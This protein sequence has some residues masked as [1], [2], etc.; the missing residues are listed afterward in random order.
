MGHSIEIQ[1]RHTLMARFLVCTIPVIGHVTPAI[2]IAQKLVQNGHEVW[3]YTGIQF[4]AKVEATGAHFVRMQQATDYSDPAQISEEGAAIRRQLTGIKQLQFDLKYVFIDSAVGQLADLTA[5]LTQFPADVVLADSFFVGASWLHEKGGPVWA[6]LGVSILFAQSGDVPPV[7]FGWQPS[8]SQMGKWRDRLL[9]RM[10]RSLV[11]GEVTAYATAARAK[12]GLD[13]PMPLVFDLVSPYLYLASTVPSFEYPRRDLPPQVHFVG[14]AV[15]VRSGVIEPLE[16]LQNLPDRPIVHVTQ[17]T[18]SNDPHQ[19]LIPTFQALADENVSVIATTGNRSLADIDLSTLPDNARIERYIPYPQLLP[20]VDL[21]ITN[22]G[23][24]GVQAALA[25]G[26]P[27][28]TAGKT[29]EKPEIGARVAWSGVGIDLKTQ[30]PKPEQIRQAVRDVLQNPRYRDR[31]RVL[32]AEIATYDF[33]TRS[34]KLLEE[35]A[36]TQAPVYDNS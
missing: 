15:P 14:P 5:I 24:Q 30:T 17:G 11:F 25:H 13:A 18:I 7:G 26:I 22:G 28:I 29:E 10:L 8:T 32:Q 19:L 9:K 12:V 6:Q 3:W 1:S 16:V 36:R 35:L 4:Q 27:L 31:A 34:V 23:F 2:P 21:M 20:H 33:A